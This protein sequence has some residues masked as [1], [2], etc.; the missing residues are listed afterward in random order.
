[1]S[2]PWLLFLLALLVTPPLAFLVFRLAKG[3]GYLDPPAS[4]EQEYRRTVSAALYAFLLF[5]PIFI[6]GY[7]KGWPRVWVFFAI[8][9][10]I[11]LFIFA[12]IGIQT[13]RLLWKLRHPKKPDADPEAEDVRPES[14]TE[15]LGP[16]L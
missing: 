9:N 5:L 2:R 1:M 7:E 16:D 3:L 4:K 13:G 10:G 14:P 15:R 6:Y 11:A 12:G 8:L